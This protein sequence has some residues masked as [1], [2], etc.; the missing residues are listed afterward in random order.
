MLQ[1]ICNFIMH[2]S[3]I[4][5]ETL[6]LHLPITVAQQYNAFEQFEVMKL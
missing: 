3:K 4:Q 5:T 6:N 2:F 1:T